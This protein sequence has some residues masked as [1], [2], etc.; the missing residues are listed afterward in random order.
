MNNEREFGTWRAEDVPFSIEYC[1][2]VMEELRAYAEAGFNKIPHGGL[3][4]GAVLLG[5]VEN[6]TIRITEWRMIHCE[7]SRGPGFTL[8]D[9]DLAGLDRLMR[10]IRKEPALEA[11]LPVGWFHTHTRSGLFL[12]TEDISVHER[13][14]PEP[15]QVALVITVAVDQPVCA[16]FFVRSAGGTLDGGQSPH[17]FVVARNR[18][19]AVRTRE[20]AILPPKVSAEAPAKSAGPT[21]PPIPEPAVPDV[22]GPHQAARVEAPAAIEP[23]ITAPQEPQEIE[24]P[25][26]ELLRTSWPFPEEPIPADIP[27]EPQAAPRSRWRAFAPLAAIAAIV[28][29]AIF[30]F[31]FLAGE[32][33]PPLTLQIEEVQDQLIIQWNRSAAVVQAAENAELAIVDG[34]EQQV[35]KLSAAE[36]RNGAITYARTSGDVNVRLTLMQ[37][38][39]PL[40]EESVRYVGQPAEGRETPAPSEP[41]GEAQL[42]LKARDDLRAEIQ[43]EENR[44]KTLEGAIRAL[45]NRLRVVRS[46][47]Q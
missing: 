4:V 24:P 39:R 17:E 43:K 7:H 10:D 21:L 6:R 46:S 36:V 11:L 40:A 25:R 26:L 27:A 18:A 29:V 3:E 8:S 1:L 34:S 5:S 30:V 33:G 15:W 23:P 35:V 44:R 13:F 14:F 31:R 22:E 2:R 12:S 42:L 9:N 19:L 38:G 45:E 47:R 32:S 28:I 41:D 16:G 20:T 37:E